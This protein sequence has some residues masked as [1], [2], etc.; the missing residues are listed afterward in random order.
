MRIYFE[1][2]RSGPR[3]HRGAATLFPAS[4]QAPHIRTLNAD[5]SRHQRLQNDDGSDFVAPQEIADVRQLV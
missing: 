4:P 2:E 3:W 5:V 1:G